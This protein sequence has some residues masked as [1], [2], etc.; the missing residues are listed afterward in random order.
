[1]P[2]HDDTIDVLAAMAFPV[3]ANTTYNTGGFV[4]NTMLDPQTTTE[5]HYRTYTTDHIT[6][7]D[8]PW[9]IQKFITEDDLEKVIHKIYQIIEDHTTLDITEEEFMKIVKDDS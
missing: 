6:I 9:R 1:M 4:H 7:D 5:H 8:R 2:P 3:T